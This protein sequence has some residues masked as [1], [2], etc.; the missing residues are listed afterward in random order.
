MMILYESLAFL[1]VFYTTIN[2]SMKLLFHN[3]DS[4]MAIC[5]IAVQTK[6]TKQASKQARSS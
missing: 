2:F 3:A 5:A 6:Y 4:G 1:C